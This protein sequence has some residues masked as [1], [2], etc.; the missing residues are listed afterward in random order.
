MKQ[1]TSRFGHFPATFET[2]CCVMDKDMKICKDHQNRWACA[3][4]FLLIAFLMAIPL[5][6][7]FAQTQEGLSQQE[8]NSIISAISQDNKLVATDGAIGDGFGRS[9]SISGDW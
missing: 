2:V 5:S 9:V 4:P 1:E 3:L 8:R 7:A 6:N